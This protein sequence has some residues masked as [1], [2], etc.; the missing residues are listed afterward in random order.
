MTDLLDA[1]ERDPR[2]K[3]SRSKAEG[4]VIADQYGRNWERPTLG[5][6]DYV[7]GVPDGLIPEGF[8]PYWFSDQTAG[9]IERKIREYWVPVTDARGNAITQQS[10]AGRMHLMMIEE[11]YYN[12]DEALRESQYRASVSE[13]LESPNLGDGIEAYKPNGA[14]S[15]SKLSISKDIN[16]VPKRDVFSPL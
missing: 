13:V 9:R 6:V 16:A 5:D 10:G 1:Q 15:N 11:K 7:L 14:E 3:P 2:A 4:G 12:E 8:K